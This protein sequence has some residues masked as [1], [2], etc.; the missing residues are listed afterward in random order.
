MEKHPEKVEK[1]SSGILLGL[2][3]LIAAGIG[4]EWILGRK[5]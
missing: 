4:I 2:F 3:T 1:K 5:K